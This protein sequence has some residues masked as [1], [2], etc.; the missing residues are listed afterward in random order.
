MPLDCCSPGL[1]LV[2]FRMAVRKT[3]IPPQP[4]DVASPRVESSM[5]STSGSPRP[6]G[7]APKCSSHSCF[8]PHI[9]AVERSL[10]F[11]HDIVLLGYIAQAGVQW[12]FSAAIIENCN[13]RQPWTPG[14]KWSA[15]ASW[16]AGT[17]GICHDARLIFVFLVEMGFH[18][19]GEAKLLKWCIFSSAA[20][21]Q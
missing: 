2:S 5:R 21:H 18:H 11:L 15:S 7:W 14:L 10:I 3:L 19:V 20:A 8:Y 17:I 9:V 16:V 6:A 12:L 13:T 1:S 4:P